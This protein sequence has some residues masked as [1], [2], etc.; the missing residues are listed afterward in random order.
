MKTPV[1]PTKLSGSLL[2]PFVVAIL[3]WTGCGRPAEPS[4]W[5]AEGSWRAVE[6]VSNSEAWFASSNGE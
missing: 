4:F 3:C 5:D 2:L 6:A 1:S